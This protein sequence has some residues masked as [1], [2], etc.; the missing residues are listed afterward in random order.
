MTGGREKEAG[1]IKKE[2]VDGVVFTVRYDRRTERLQVRESL[3][4]GKS[5]F[6]NTIPRTV[7]K[8]QMCAIGD[9]P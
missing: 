3:G 5:K 6:Q 2:R 9:S 1:I 8:L 4:T 7:R